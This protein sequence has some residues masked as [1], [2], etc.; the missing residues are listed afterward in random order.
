MADCID[1]I[2]VGSGPNG[3]AAAIALAQSGLRVVVFEA[4]PT[5]GGGTRSAELTLPGFVHDV[6]S[7]VHPLAAASPFFRSLPLQEYGLEW[8]EPPAML[9]HPFDDG[10]AAIVYRS[11]G[12]TAAALG[13]DGAAYRRLMQPLIDRWS[14]LEGSILGP[15]G[16]PRHPIAVAQFG[17]Q[18]LRSAE[19]LARRTFGGEPARALFAGHAAH[20][21]LPLDRTLTAGFGLVLGAV[22]HLVG[23]V[24]PRGGA[25]RIA[26]AL[27]AHLRSLGGEIRTSSPV[28]SLDD[29]P[30]ARAVLCDLSPKPFLR[31][32]GHRLPA[33]YRRRLE[34]YRVRDGCLQG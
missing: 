12:K 25:Q 8:V 16:W 22:A 14:A 3:L 24:V 29:L 23:W 15:V 26:D 5:V 1:A 32:A 7:A 19:G 10:P 33:G 28:I 6:C 21:M 20:G 34:R 27:A 4:E 9:A 31:I 18:A 11:L 2:V 30:P 17:L 13:E